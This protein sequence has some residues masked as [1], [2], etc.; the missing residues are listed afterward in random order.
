MP[1]SFDSLQVVSRIQKLRKKAGLE[2]TDIVELYFE[3]L[4]NKKDVFENIVNSQVPFFI[5][6]DHANNSFIVNS[7]FDAV[8]EQYIKEALGSPL[9]HFSIASEA[10]VSNINLK[11]LT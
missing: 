2:P 9:L 4:G 1:Y 11:K 3:P 10:T 6:L 5:H 8:Q 7:F